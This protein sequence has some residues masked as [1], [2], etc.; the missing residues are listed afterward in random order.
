ME[1]QTLFGLP[2][3]PLIVHA[4]VV[5]IPLAALGTVAIALWSE[6][7]RRI[8][9]IVVVFAA[10]A[11]VTALLAQGSGQALEE[12]VHETRFSEEHAEQGDSLPWFALPIALAAG[13][14]MVLDRRRSQGDPDDQPPWMGPAVIAVAAAAVVFSVAG[15]VRLAHVGHSGAKATWQDV[16]DN[17]VNEELEEG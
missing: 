4:A 9:W 2:A 13:G 1:I 14:V 16:Q 12:R 7:R 15:T 5:L 8:G 3:H 11:F 6:A 10:V 17:P